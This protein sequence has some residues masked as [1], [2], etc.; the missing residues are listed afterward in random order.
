MVKFFANTIFK[1]CSEQLQEIE[2][3]EREALIYMLLED[4]HDIE[5]KDIFLNKEILLDKDLL[6]SQL[7]RLRK[8]EPI[9]HIIGFSFFR[10]RKFKVSNDVLIPRPETEELVELIKDFA[11]PSS[12]IVDIGTGSGCIAISLALE[13]EN[14]NITAVDVSKEA[15]AMARFNAKNLGAKIDFIEAN[16]LEFENRETYDF[17]VSNPPYVRKSEKLNMDSNVLNYEP[18]IALF[19]ED[20]NPLIFYEAISRFGMK[21]LSKN[22]MVAVEINSF[23]GKSTK[24]LFENHGYTDVELITDFYEKDRFILAKK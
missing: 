17:I 7:D 15:L 3:A 10:S 12:R 18:S 5:K 6:E 9:Q 20:K 13:I 19:V 11:Q 1:H 21:N 24:E 16:F 8:N 23:L 14:S 22:G 4:S 2:I